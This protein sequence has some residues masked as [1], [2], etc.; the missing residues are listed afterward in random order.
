M[1]PVSTFWY[2]VKVNRPP[3]VTP[4]ARAHACAYV[5]RHPNDQIYVPDI[6]K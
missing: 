5:E 6:R 2:A 4:V 1:N 3:E